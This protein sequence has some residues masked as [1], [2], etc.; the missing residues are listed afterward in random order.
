MG[1]KGVATAGLVALALVLVS[2]CTV[3]GSLRLYGQPVKIVKP[4]HE[5]APGCG[6]EYVW[7]DGRATYY[8]DGTWVV[9][10]SDHRA[11]VVYEKP[12]GYLLREESRIKTGATRASA[13]PYSKRPSAEKVPPKPAPAAEKAPPKPAPSAEKVPPKPAPS[14]EKAPPKPPPSAEKA[15]PKKD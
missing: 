8:V 3:K 15:P 9:Y 7:Y 11:W 10:A 6:H 13:V 1:T 5:H 12:S 4:V 14:A 2:G